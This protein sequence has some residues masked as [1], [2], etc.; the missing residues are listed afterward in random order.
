MKLQHKSIIISAIIMLVILGNSCKTSRQQQTAAKPVNQ[1]EEMN[2]NRSVSEE[3]N[4]GPDKKGKDKELPGRMTEFSFDMYRQ[5]SNEEG[6]KNFS[7]SPV[8]LNMAMA[9]VYAGARGSTLENMSNIMKFDQDVDVFHQNYVQYFQSLSQ[10]SDDTLIEFNIANRIFLEKTSLILDTY[11]EDIETYHGGEFELADFL[12]NYRLEE[13]K[14]N[15]WVEKMTRDRIKDLIPMGT[16]DEFTRIVLVNA[17]YI[18]SAW[19]FPFM[20]YATKEDQF[21]T[22]SL[23]SVQKPFMSQTRR[24]IP[25]VS[26]HGYEVLELPYTSQGLSLLILLPDLEHSREFQRFIP[27]QQQYEEILSQLRPEFVYM[28]I[29]K[30]KTESQFSIKD[31]F[32]EMGMD[33]PFSD[34]ADFTGISTTG[35]LAISEVLQKV[36]FEIDEKGTEAAAATAVIVTTTSMAPDMDVPQPI[37]FIANRPFIFILKENYFNTPLFIGQVAE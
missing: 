9:L 25:Y 26:M 15:A 7:F 1:K 14:I 35:E 36:F 6:S 33:L 21:T 19:K 20:E 29:P 4:S 12:N 13:K 16:L 5:I 8:S 24:G 37:E 11:K 28:E 32:R 34:Q 18:K 2:N 31:H 30:F 10:F 17:L 23:Q 27:D 22:A 3:G